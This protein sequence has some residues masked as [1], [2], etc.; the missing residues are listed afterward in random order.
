MYLIKLKLK[1]TFTGLIVKLVQLVCTLYR[2]SMLLRILWTF[3]CN[4]C[5]ATGYA[6][7]NFSS[8]LHRLSPLELAST[9]RSHLPDTVSTWNDSHFTPSAMNSTQ[10]K[11]FKQI[12]CPFFFLR[13]FFINCTVCK[14]VLYSNVYAVRW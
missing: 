4:R 12:F 8:T 1:D 9:F 7:S 10:H 2:A 11:I 3:F 14:C 6:R 13:Q 5:S